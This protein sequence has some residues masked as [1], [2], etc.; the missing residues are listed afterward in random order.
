MIPGLGYAYAGEYANAIRSLILNGLFIYGMT[1][2][3]EDEHWGAFSIITFF[4][5]TWYS[6]SI[7]GGID[8]S[9]RYNQKR[10]QASLQMID[11]HSRFKPDLNQMPAVVLKYQF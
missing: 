4:E 9:H 5:L 10:L 3:A 2:T 11:D 6:G 7:Y 1:D 8:A